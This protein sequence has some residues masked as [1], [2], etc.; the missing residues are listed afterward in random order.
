L[1]CETRQMVKNA[2]ASR[3]VEWSFKS[4]YCSHESSDQSWPAPEKRTIRSGLCEPFHLF[5]TLIISNLSPPFSKKGLIIKFPISTHH[6]EYLL[7][8]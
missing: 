7:S 2:T 3:G 4:H 5:S 6:L 8:F 1:W